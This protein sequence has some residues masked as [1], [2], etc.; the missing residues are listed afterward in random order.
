MSRKEFAVAA[1][2]DISNTQGFGWMGVDEEVI[3]LWMMAGR[4]SV[5]SW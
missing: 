4:E 3:I 2:V 1:L 5:V